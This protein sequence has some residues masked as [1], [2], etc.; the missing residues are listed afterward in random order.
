MEED[1]MED[2]KQS[3]CGSTDHDGYIRLEALRLAHGEAGVALEAYAR[4]GHERVIER[5]RAYYEFVKN[6]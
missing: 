5:A 2:S 6:G 3:A 4:P 1:Q